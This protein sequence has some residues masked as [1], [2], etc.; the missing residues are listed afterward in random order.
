MSLE[1]SAC[2]DLKAFERRLTEVI[3]ALQPSTLR[4]RILLSI[5]SITTAMTAWYWLVDPR[6]S[7]VPL[8][9]SLFNHFIFTIAAIILIALF[10]Y[11]IHKLVIA[12]QIITLRT[13]TVLN[14]F[15]MSC[16]DS[17]KLIL[18]PRPRLE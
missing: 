17:G 5:V 10:F 2:E 1:S 15:N 4:W 8:L 3:A 13:R 12:P 7:V 9:E 18:K 11:G 6:T 14:D 16:D